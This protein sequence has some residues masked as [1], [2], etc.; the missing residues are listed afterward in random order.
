MAS[1]TPEYSVTFYSSDIL[2]EARRAARSLERAGEECQVPVILAAVAVEAFLNDVNGELEISIRSPVQ[3]D[4]LRLVASLM[5][6]AQEERTSTRFRIQL[7]YALATGR[8][9]DLGAKPYQDYDLLVRLRNALVHAGPVWSDFSESAKPNKL[10]E[11]LAQ[12]RLVDSRCHCDAITAHAGRFDCRAN[13]VAHF[14]PLLSH[15]GIV[16]VCMRYIKYGFEQNSDSHFLPHRSPAIYRNR[17]ARLV[18]C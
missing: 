10:V 8:P 12:R 13:L 14:T 7:S 4:R 17:L 15:I 6:L 1:K 9:L 5:H 2:G 11:A 3:S 16:H 18:V